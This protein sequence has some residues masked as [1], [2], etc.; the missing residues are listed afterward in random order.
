MFNEI[1]EM[2]ELRA[3][4]QKSLSNLKSLDCHRFYDVSVVIRSVHVMSNE[5]NDYYVNNYSNWNTYNIVYDEDFLQS[6]SRRV[7]SY[8]ENNL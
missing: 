1:N 4:K 6:D 3:W 7:K 2:I 8:R 5:R